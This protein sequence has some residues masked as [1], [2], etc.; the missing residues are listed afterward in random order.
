MAPKNKGGHR[1][2]LSKLSGNAFDRGFMRDMVTADR[3]AA[4][5]FKKASNGKD[6]DIKAWASKTRRRS[7]SI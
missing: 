2:R 5:S 6:A 3:N 7:R 1:D 4:D